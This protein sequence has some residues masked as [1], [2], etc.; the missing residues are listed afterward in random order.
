MESHV[1]CSNPAKLVKVEEESRRLVFSHR[2]ASRI[3]CKFEVR[4]RAL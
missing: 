4:R 1:G 3:A 2:R